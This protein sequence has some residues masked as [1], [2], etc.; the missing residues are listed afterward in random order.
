MPRVVLR[1]FKPQDAPAARKILMDDRV[2]KTYMLPD[3]SEDEANKLFYRLMELS[4]DANHYVRAISVGGPLV[5]WIND[6]DHPAEGVELGWV[7]DPEYQNR[8]YATAAV[9]LAFEELRSFGI[10][11]VIAAAFVEN[12]ASIRVMEKTGMIPME[13]TEEIEYRGQTHSCVYYHADLRGV[14]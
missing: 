14:D 7:V 8:G 9:N 12:A 10:R 13:K 2:N 11:T 1:R 5:G 3:L 4:C 6:T